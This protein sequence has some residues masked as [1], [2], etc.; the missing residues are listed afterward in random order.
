MGMA[1]GV[2]SVMVPTLV[3]IAVETKQLTT[4]STATANFDGM[5]ESIKYATLSALERPT[6]PTNI[7]AAK[8]MSSIVMMFLSPTP[9]P[10]SVSFSSN[11]SARFWQQATSSAMRKMTTIGME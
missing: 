8:K 3:P 11:D 7:P 5:I 1:M 6:T 10:I 4:N 9:R 2:M